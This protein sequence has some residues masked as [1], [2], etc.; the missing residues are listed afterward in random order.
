VRLKESENGLV[1]D[2]HGPSLDRKSH[3]VVLEEKSIIQAKRRMLVKDLRKYI[4]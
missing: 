4:S 1:R 3:E 2:S